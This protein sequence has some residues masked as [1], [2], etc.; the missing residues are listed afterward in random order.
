M[1]ISLMMSTATP[2]VSPSGYIY[3]VMQQGAG[4]ALSLIHI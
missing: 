2:M 1:K 3:S 4:L